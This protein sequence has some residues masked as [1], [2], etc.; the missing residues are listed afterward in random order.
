MLDIVAAA[1]VRRG[2]NTVIDTLGL[3]AARRSAAVALGRG[4]GLPVVAVRFSTA[5]DV[6][7]TRNRLRDRPVPAPALKA[8]FQRAPRRSTWPPT[9][10]IW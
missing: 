6:C 10:S 8:Q 1:R 2:L 7:R 5:L 4:A 3:D 9:G